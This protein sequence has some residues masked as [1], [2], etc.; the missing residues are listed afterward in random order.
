MSLVF[1]LVIL[2]VCV[3]AIVL[4]AKRGFIKSVMGVCT[5][6]AALCLAYA[7]T[8]TL[9]G[10]IRTSA[11]LVN[12]S[13]SIGDTI[14]SLSRTEEGGYNLEKMFDDMPDAF[15]QIL[16]RYGADEHELAGEIVTEEAATEAVVDALAK[17]I[18][19]PVVN[20]ISRVVAFLAIF[21]AAVVV[22]KLLT[23]L[24]DLL[25]QLPVLKT[26]NT[27]LGLVVGI[28][29][30]FFWIMVLCPLSITLIRAL[31][32]ISPDLF[33]ESVIENSVILSIFEN[34]NIGDY[35]NH[36]LG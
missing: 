11:P 16:H 25:F 35:L 28:V 17:D 8:P 1:D 22:L 3:T 29:I 20:V 24:L 15:Q 4:G 9:A 2:A 21:V 33:N 36:L 5:L 27:M 6:I 34:N 19:D 7:F 26:A 13:E 10:Y 31:S 14:K 23:L 18:A 12:I 32:S 30:A